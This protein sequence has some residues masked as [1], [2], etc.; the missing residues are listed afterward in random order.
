MSAVSVRI[1]DKKPTAGSM[2]EQQLIRGC[3]EGN[4]AYHRKL[5]DLYAPKLMTVCLLYA[6]SRFDAEDYLQEGFVKIFTHL[7][8][9]RPIGPFEGWMRRIVVNT[10]IE[11]LRKSKLVVYTDEELTSPEVAGDDMVSALSAKEILQFVHHLPDGYRNIF[12]LYVF[13][14]YTHKEIGEL[15]GIA[16]GTSKSQF[17]RARATLQRTILPTPEM[18]FCCS[19]WSCH[20]FCTSFSP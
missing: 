6:K 8:T 14:G 13:E 7:H 11:H 16:E 4:A 17:A 5:Y 9:Y 20:N 2:T 3:I 15:L 12:N 10:A 18:A 1:F 19:L